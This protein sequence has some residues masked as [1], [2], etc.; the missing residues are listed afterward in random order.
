MERELDEP[1][2]WAFFLCGKCTMAN[3]QANDPIDVF[4]WRRIDERLTTS[5]QPTEAQLAAIHALGV[6][7]VI[8]LGLH[9]H[10]MA[11]VDEAA[12]V[13]ALGMTYIHMPVEFGNPTDAD[14]DRFKAKMG[15]LHGQT[16]HV[17]CIANLRVSAFL[18]RY[19]QNLPG[20]VEADVRSEMDGIWRPGGVWATFIGDADAVT[21]DHLYAR[22]D[23]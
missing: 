18:Y 17:H 7:H 9:T 2:A 8:N 22:R 19:R 13:A 15:E 23:Y 4:M 20:M 12:S 21:R 11:L 3:S 6:T 5:G 16:I 10:E 1:R 14:F